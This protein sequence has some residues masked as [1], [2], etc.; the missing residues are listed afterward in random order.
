MIG[1]FVPMDQETSALLCSIFDCQRLLLG[2]EKIVRNQMFCQRSVGTVNRWLRSCDLCGG[3]LRGWLVT[4][5]SSSR[6]AM[7][8]RPTSDGQ[9]SVMM[10][11]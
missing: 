1:A 6:R 10:P 11:R 8:N 2:E 3:Y 9:P 5:L 7:W 4:S